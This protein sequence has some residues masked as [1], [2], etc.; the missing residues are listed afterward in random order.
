MVGVDRRDSEGDVNTTHMGA[1]LATALL[2]T[3]GCGMNED[4]FNKKAAKEHC[5]QLKKCERGYFDGEW[6]NVSECFDDV[7]DE[8]EDVAED[9]DDADCDFEPD[10]AKTCVQSLKKMDCNDFTDG[11]WLDDC[12]DVYDCS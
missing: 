8:Y 9:A 3:A 12:E 2:L 4:S 5:Q 1:L 7:V 6:D 10:E 11:D